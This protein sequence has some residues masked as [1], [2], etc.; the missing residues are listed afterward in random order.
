MTGIIRKW[1]NSLGLRIPKGIAEQSNLDAGTTVDIRVQDNEIIIT[2]AAAK[3]N[4]DDLLA[5]ITPENV[6]AE[7]DTG[8]AQG[9][10]AW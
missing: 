7:T 5:K 1:G 10:K 3:H 4:L 9:M 6:H 8:P 2:P